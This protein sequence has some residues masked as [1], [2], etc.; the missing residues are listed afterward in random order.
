MAQPS[1]FNKPIKTPAATE[2]SGDN[3]MTTIFKIQVFNSSNMRSEVKCFKTREQADSWFDQKKARTNGRCP[4]GL[5]TA[6]SYV[7]DWG[8]IISIAKNY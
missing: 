3:N 2:N 5:T 8:K 7:N 4:S 6:F 1:T